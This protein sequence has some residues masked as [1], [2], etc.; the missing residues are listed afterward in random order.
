MSAFTVNQ[1]PAYA[2]YGSKTDQGSEKLDFSVGG[3]LLQ[4]SATTDLYK[5]IGTRPHLGLSPVCPPIALTSSVLSHSKLAASSS[6]STLHVLGPSSAWLQLQAGQDC[7]LLYLARPGIFGQLEVVCSPA[8]LLLVSC[9][10]PRASRL[11]Q[12]PLV[13]FMQFCGPGKE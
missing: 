4:S 13:S 12:L 1:H 9:R 7:A 11:V 6:P 5:P 8:F 3:Y 10:S 2:I